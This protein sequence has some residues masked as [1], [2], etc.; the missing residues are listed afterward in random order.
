MMTARFGRQVDGK[1]MT[2][3]DIPRK[4]KL[5]QLGSPADDGRSPVLHRV[6]QV[7]DALQQPG[8]VLESG[9]GV[10]AANRAADRHYGL[11]RREWQETTFLKATGLRRRT[12]QR[13]FR[14]AGEEGEAFQ[15]G[16]HLRRNGERFPADIRVTRIDWDDAGAFLVV[17]QDLSEHQRAQR[18]FQDSRARFQQTFDHAAVGM[19]LMLEQGYFLQAN[20]AMADIFGYSRVQLMQLQFSELLRPDRQAEILARL[21]EA[22]ACDDS[23]HREISFVRSDGS[24][25]WGELS[26][27]WFQAEDDQP[28]YWILILQETTSRHLAEEALA[29]SEERYRQVVHQVSDVLFQL[30]G[31]SRISFLNPAWEKTSR[32]KTTDGIGRSLYDFVVE[33]QRDRLRDIVSDLRKKGQGS[34]E[35]E[36]LF[37]FS[38]EH[39]LWMLLNLMVDRHGRL[40]GSL[41]DIHRQKGEKD[42][43]QGERSFLQ[44]VVDGV[45]DPLLVVDLDF[46]VQLLNRAARWDSRLFSVHGEKPRCYEVH[47]G[48][49]VSCSGEDH[50]CPMEEVRKTGQA[51]TVL[52][53][54]QDSDGNQ[55]IYEVQASPLRDEMGQ[56]SGIIETF[57]DI[58]YLFET[59]EQLQEKDNRLDYL[60]QH[61][62]LTGL[63]NRSQF[64]V[65]L[66]RLMKR[67]SETG[68]KLAVL[69]LDL[70]RFKNIND[71]LGHGTGDLVLVEVA[72]RLRET[73]RDSDV[74]ARLGGDEFIILLDNI[75]SAEKAERVAGKVLGALEPQLDINDCQLFVTGSLGI[76]IF[77]DDACSP[78]DMLKSADTAL[79]RAKK[80]GR[81][82]YRFYTSDMNARSRELL[83]LE[84]S[85]RQ[86]LD[87]EQLVLHYQPQIDLFT[88][89]TRGVEALVRWEHPQ[90]GMISPGDFIPLAEET[91]LIVPMGQWVL[92]QACRQNAAWVE[93]GFMP[94]RMTVNISARQFLKEDLLEDLVGVLRETGLDP[95]LLELEITE[96]MIMH[97][98][99]AATRVMDSI[100]A[101][102]VHL[103]VDDFGTGYSSLAH[104]KRFPLTTLKI[105]RAF[106]K[107]IGQNNED[108]AIVKAIVALAHS[109]DLQVIAE[110]IET[111][112]QYRFLKAAG[113]DQGQ[114]FLFSRPVPAA[115]ILSFLRPCPIL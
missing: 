80:A 49:T 17:A 27:T 78:E 6:Q 23:F 75:G 46:R 114:G 109:L 18:A 32:L 87:E 9:G 13:L 67:A 94:L 24:N 10:L 70:D 12:L 29:S 22:R 92:R 95:G 100:A 41:H 28:G 36:F 84:A 97:D 42:R 62:L 37:Q 25:G 106:V 108:E 4:A 110:G 20:Q 113:C 34:G 57:R 72:R 26:A 52:H 68:R 88:G 47:L 58:T 86:A 16:E 5:I 65:R 56:M 103:A 1:T 91:G 66:K 54:R 76:S 61:D 38:S 30:D 43:L 101:E 33:S 89:Q 64:L 51:V 48:R 59:E 53:N 69:L 77:P 82:S 115:K 50:P 14:L 85:F 21:Q 63:P 104:L 11:E 98:V 107:D 79:F 44:S 96:S 73:L 55:R 60:I 2:R 7:L 90:K 35:G 81:N 39:Q 102:G 40:T 3:K 71:S 99:A 15:E 31:E 83:L 19:G 111:E 93:A 105:D 45:C 112:E 8:W 74:I